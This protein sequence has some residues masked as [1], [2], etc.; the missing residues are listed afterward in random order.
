MKV[1]KKI[2]P[3]KIKEKIKK[4]MYINRYKNYKKYCIKNK[5]KECILFGTPIHGNLGDHAIAYAEHK[6][7]NTVGLEAFEVYTYTHEY[8]FEYISKNISKDALI[9]VTGGGSMGS[10]WTVEE[11]L[12]RK[13]V[14]SFKNNKI[15]IFPQTIFYKDDD[16]GKVELEK[17]REI[18]NSHK[19]LYICAREE[20]SYNIIKENYKNANILLVPDI[21]LSLP[22][23]NF[24]EERDKILLCIRHD[25]ESNLSN[26][27][28]QYIKEAVK[29]LNIKY[30]W[31][32]TVINSDI[33]QEKREEC[34]MSKFRQFSKAKIVIT[35]RL[36]GMI[37]AVITKTPCIVLSNYNHKVKGVYNWIKELNYIEFLEDI[38]DIE[39]KCNKLL[40]TYEKGINEID[41]SKNFKK[42]VDLIKE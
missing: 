7:L 12:I 21:V 11:E 3:K 35:D 8:N 14:T 39:E 5:I 36:H 29:K 1:L 26:E 27:N 15:I 42:L 6:L 9:C 23:F 10:Q 31:T 37:F 32:D 16:F 28:L 22:V 38:N 34:L 4:I 2:I 25:V 33:T 40:T 18:Y 41:M 30:E 19:N 17:S 24:N 13:V 20:K